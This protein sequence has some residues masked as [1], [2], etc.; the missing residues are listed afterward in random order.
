MDTL[1]KPNTLRACGIATLAAMLVA[2]PGAARAIDEFSL[3]SDDVVAGKLARRHYSGA[4][5][6]R[7]CSGDNVSP[8][9]AWFGAP[10]GTESFALVMQDLDA[11]AGTPRIH[12]VVIDIPEF[13]AEITRG[14]GS[15]PARL[16]AGATVA[17]NQFG[18]RGYVGL[19]PPAG[20]R[21]NYVFRLSALSVKK[22]DTRKAVD[23][24]DLER[25]IRAA[26]I[27]SAAFVVRQE[28]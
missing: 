16:P 6:G 26:T 3:D 22:L 2:H 12:W 7:G 17:A 24:A 11:G 5:Q 21:R 20:Q 4:E 28:R 13:A 8:H 18:V 1:L 23:A 15:E 10:P 25:L 14:A 19:C 9:L 27:N